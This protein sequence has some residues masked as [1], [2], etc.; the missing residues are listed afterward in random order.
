MISRSTSTISDLAKPLHLLFRDSSNEG[1]LRV[2]I[3]NITDCRPKLRY[4]GC[5]YVSLAVFSVDWHLTMARTERPDVERRHHCR[6]SQYGFGH[7]RPLAVSSPQRRYPLSVARVN[8]E[9]GMHWGFYQFLYIVLNA[10]V[11]STTSQKS[12]TLSLSSFN[13]RK[14]VLSVISNS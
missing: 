5:L 4:L 3:G 7:R 10:R 12:R 11:Q 8:E 2:T 6:I 9:L 1:R 13:I 14:Q